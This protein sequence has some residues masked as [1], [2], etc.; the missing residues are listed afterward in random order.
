MGGAARPRPDL[1]E[2]ER[3]PTLSRSGAREGLWARNERMATEEE[4]TAAVAVTKAIMAGGGEEGA[5]ERCLAQE[6]GYEE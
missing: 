3:R 5:T 6:G 1:H 4:A 2:V